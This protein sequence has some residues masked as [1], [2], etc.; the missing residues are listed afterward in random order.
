MSSKPT[1]AS[2]FTGLGGLDLG[3]EK[4]G[5]SVSWSNDLMKSAVTCYKQNFGRDM[6]LGDINEIPID[7]IPNTDIIIGGPPCQSFSLVGKRL[8]DDPRGK[9]INKFVEIISEKRPQAFVMENVPGLAASK[10]NGERLTIVLKKQFEKLGYYVEVMKLDSSEFL[11][12]QKRK[13]IF[14]VGTCTSRFKPPDSKKFAKEVYN[15]DFGSFDIGSKSAIGDLGIP[16]GMNELSKYK[17]SVPSEFAKI[18]RENQEK[19]VTLHEWPTMSERD[20][21][22][23]SF[24]PPGGNYTSVPDEHSTTRIMNFK[25]T[26]GRTTAYARLHPTKPSYTVNTQFRRPNV[27][28]NIHYEYPRLITAREA[29]RFQ[30]FPDCFVLNGITKTD[31]NTLIGNAVPVI[32]AQALA[33]N[34]QK[35]LS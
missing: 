26:G 11:V 30:S 17:E 7:E 28:S 8:K 22:L 15:L 18:M 2:L 32:L 33:H 27:G 13:R 25:K 23:I 29:L 12:P 6:V 10:V 5:Y 35:Y 24:I 16:V 21:I 34:L 31:R 14:I 1:I 4:S 3:F 9:L 20:K 19:M